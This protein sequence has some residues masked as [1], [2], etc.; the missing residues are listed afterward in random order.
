MYANGPG[1]LAY[2]E[3]AG[4]RLTCPED[5]SYGLIFT[6][7]GTPAGEP[8]L[9]I[10]AWFGKFTKD[11]TLVYDETQSKY[12]WNQYWG[13]T[14]KDEITD[15]V[16]AFKNV[17]ILR[18]TNTASNGIYQMVDFVTGGSGWFACNGKFIPILWS[19]AD[20]TSPIRITTVDGEPVALSVGNTYM[21]II[22]MHNE[23]KIDGV[24]QQ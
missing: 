19:C 2:T 13:K 21:G 5:T 14:M 1:L 17:L 7:D 11:T 22:Q 12:V 3:Q 10:N 18:A 9:E 4:I 15:E 8:A 6:E 16:E 24:V 20:E 23:V